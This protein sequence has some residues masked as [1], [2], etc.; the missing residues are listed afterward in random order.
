MKTWNINKDVAQ[1]FDNRGLHN[2]GSLVWIFFYNQKTSVRR[3][4]SAAFYVKYYHHF[5]FDAG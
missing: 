4:A 3:V 2:N 5:L 1:I